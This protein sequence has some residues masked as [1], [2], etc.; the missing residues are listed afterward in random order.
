MY[1]VIF[2]HFDGL[3][4]EQFE[5]VGMRYQVLIFQNRSSFNDFVARVRAVMNVECDFCLHGRYNMGGNRS[6]YVMPSLG[7]EDEWQ[8]V[9]VMW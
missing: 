1:R 7:S 2:L 3:V 4:S 6:I 5:L 8:S 9:Q